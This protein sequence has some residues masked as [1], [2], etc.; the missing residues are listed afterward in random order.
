MFTTL[1]GLLREL[2]HGS[3]P[4]GGFVLNPGDAGLLAGLDGLTASDASLSSQGGATIAAHVAHLSYGLSLMN[5]WAAGEDPFASADWTAAW[6]I[7]A[8]SDDEWAA[9]RAEL[10]SQLD[11]WHSA[12]ATRRELLP[13][14][15]HGV[16]GSGVHL[17]YH[18]GAMRQSHAR[19][20]G[21][22]DGQA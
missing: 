12:I 13:V 16:I 7:G 8:V 20:R 1:Q 11:A 19:L 22:K 2:A 4:T 17:G 3:A 21:P 15:L 14:E 9:L 5:R 10:R 6:Q 18:L